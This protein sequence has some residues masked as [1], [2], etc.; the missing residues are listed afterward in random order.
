[1]RKM[2]LPNLFFVNIMPHPSAV[3]ISKFASGIMASI[4]LS[5]IW[6]EIA[7]TKNGAMCT[8]AQPQCLLRRSPW[9]LGGDQDS[10]T[11]V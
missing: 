2:R 7:S 5:T 10:Y 9:E 4:F 6:K 3:A 11:C 8:I 1:M